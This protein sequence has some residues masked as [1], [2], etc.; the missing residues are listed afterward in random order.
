MVDTARLSGERLADFELDREESNRRYDHAFAVVL[1]HTSA[2]ELDEFWRLFSTTS[3]ASE[4]HSNPMGKG[5]S[6]SVLGGEGA[7]I[8]EMFESPAA[9]TFEGENPLALAGETN[10]PMVQRQVL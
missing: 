7:D 2:V 1:S 9:P 6:N 10:E 4:V 3:V 8:G 5:W